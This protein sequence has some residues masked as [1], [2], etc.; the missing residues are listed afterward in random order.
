MAVIESNSE[1]ERERVRVAVEFVAGELGV[2]MLVMKAG[3]K[4]L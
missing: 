3:G 2:R 4:Y 1:R